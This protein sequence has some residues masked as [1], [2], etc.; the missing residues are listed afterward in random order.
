MSTPYFE[1]LLISYDALTSYSPIG[2]NVSEEK[3]Y[4]FANIVQTLEI[5]PMLG[6]LLYDELIEQI[7]TET[8]TP[9]NKALL[10]NLAP[11]FSLATFY[12]AI[13][14]LAYDVCEKGITKNHSENSEALNHTEIAEWRNDIMGEMN[15]AREMFIDYMCGCRD[16]YPTWMPSKDV[17][18]CREKDP[19]HSTKGLIYFP[20]KKKNC[21][22]GCGN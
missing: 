21:G 18:K 16:L 20:N 3:V 14:S 22:C 2:K 8:L 4:G 5:Q 15:H 13:R 6:S 11:W 9:E 1:T 10:V 7:N 17:C 12:K 19:D